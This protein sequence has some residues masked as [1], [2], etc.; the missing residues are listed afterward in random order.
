MKDSEKF[1]GFKEEIIKENAEKYGKELNQKFGQTYI[2]EANLKFKKLSKYQFEEQNK[3]ANKI[4]DL[5]IKAVQ[6]KDVSSDISQELCKNHQLWIKTY[7][8]TYTE[9]AHMALVE[10]YLID[11]R[12]TQYYDKIV[13]GGTLFLRDAMKIYLNIKK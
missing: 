4:S 2:D 8:P 13:S 1:A 12:F 10:M 7:W 5:L 11:E 3:L 9:E 6:S